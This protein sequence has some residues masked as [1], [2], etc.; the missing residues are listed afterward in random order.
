MS[1]S[2]TLQQL[3]SQL[4]SSV[5]GGNLI[6]N[7]TN[8]AS[9]T[10]GWSLQTMGLSSITIQIPDPSTGIVYDASKAVLTIIGKCTLFTGWDSVSYTI[11]LSSGDAGNTLTYANTAIAATY[12]SFN[13][14]G[15]A[16]SS[17]IP[18]NTIAAKLLPS[19][20]MQNVPL[21]VIST[22]VTTLPNCILNFG[23]SAN[24][25]TPAWSLISALGLSM[26]TM[27]FQVS[28]NMN[29]NAV[30]SNSFVLSGG[31]SIGSIETEITVTLPVDVFS[32]TN[33][34]SLAFSS[35]V[36]ESGLNIANLVQN[37]GGVN[38]YQEFPASLTALLEF[39]LT[40]FYV[41]FNPSTLTV[42]QLEINIGAPAWSVIP[43]EFSIENTNFGVQ[44]LNPFSSTSRSTT[45]F[46]NGT[47]LVGSDPQH[48]V[49]TLTVGA[50]LPLGSSNWLFNIY[51]EI[52]NV[53]YSTLV[54]STPGMN[55]YPP[56]AAPNGFQLE[57]I[58]LEYLNISFNPTTVTLSEVDLSVKSVLDFPIVPNII[59]IQNPYFS[60]SLTNPLSSSNNNYS[61]D[62]GG[63]ITLTNAPFLELNASVAKTTG[64][65]FNAGLAPGATINIID[66]LDQ[67]FA[68]SSTVPSWVGSTLEITAF[69]IVIKTPPSGKTSPP[70]EYIVSGTVV[71]ELVVGAFSLPAMTA[72]V[73]VDY[74]SADG[75]KPAV[76]SGSITVSTKLFGL[77]FLIGYKFGAAETDVY[78]VWNGIKAEYTSTSTYSK[79]TLTVSNLS[80]GSLISAVMS[81]LI[82]GFTLSPPWNLLNDINLD[83][84]SIVCTQ[85]IQA[86]DQ[87]KNSLVV[88]IPI[89]LNLGFIDIKTATLTRSGSGS[90]AQTYLGF[91]GT[92]L[93]FTI[94]SDSQNESAKQ[95]ADKGAPVNNMPTVPGLGGNI[96]DLQYF[97][98]GQ[99]VALYPTQNLT[100]VTQAVSELKTV[101]GDPP[102]QQPGQKA[103]IPIPPKPNSAP[104]KS[105]LIFDET[106]NWLIGLQ[107]KVMNT[108]SL[109]VVFNDPNLYG[110]AVGL[111]G[112]SAKIFAGLN[113][114]I[115]YKKV[116]DS[117]GVYQLDLQLPTAMRTLELGEVSITLPSAAIQIYT[118]G[119]FMVDL[120]FPWSNNFS[121][122]F[123][124]QVF[125]F[126]GQGGFYFG[127]LNS[128]TSSSVP[129]SQVGSF[130]P[131][132][133]LGVG[134]SLGVG[135]NINEGILSAGLSLMAVGV[136]QGVLARFN[137]NDTSLYTGDGDYYFKATG[138]FGL[139]GRIYGSVNFAIIS[140]S[141][142]LTAYA[143]I[144]ISLECYNVIDISFTAGVSISLTVTVNLGLFKIHITLKFSA[145]ISASFTI[146]TNRTALAPWNQQVKS[147]QLNKRLMSSTSYAVIP[148]YTILWQP[149]QPDT[150]VALNLMYLPLLSVSNAASST[151]AQFVN[152]LFIDAP[153]P[154]STTGSIDSSFTTL[155]TATL[156]W[157]INAIINSDK[158][159]TVTKVS[160]LMSQAVTV[161]ELQA[162]YDYLTY[163]SED[164][165]PI[166]YANISNHQEYDIRKFFDTYFKVTIQAQ[167]VDN[168]SENN[169]TVIPIFPDLKLNYSLNGTVGTPVDFSANPQPFSYLGEVQEQLGQLTVGYQSETEVANDH[170]DHFIPVNDPSLP[171]TPPDVS[172]ATFII[173]DYFEMMV[174]NVIQDAI[175]A[176]EK[177]NYH[178]DAT[179]SLGDVVNHFTQ[180]PLNNELTADDVVT[181]NATLLLNKGQIFNLSG[182]TY[183]IASNDTLNSIVTTYNANLVTANYITA[184]DLGT[185][186]NAGISGLIVQ[187]TSIVVSGFNPYIVIATDS[188][189]TIAD[190]LVPTTGSANATITQVINA[191]ADLKALT[192]L[193]LI[194]IPSLS[195]TTGDTDTFQSLSTKYGVKTILLATDNLQV[196]FN[197][198]SIIVPGITTLTVQDV[199]NQV[200]TLANINTYS[201]MAARFLLHG[202]NLPDPTDNTKTKPLYV[203]TGQQLTIPPL[204]QN[205]TY[206]LEL[207]SCANGSWIGVD[208]SAASLNVDNNEISRINNLLLQNI[209]QDTSPQPP[210]ALTLY[211]DAYLAFTLKSQIPWQYP[212]VLSLP[213]GT[214]PAQVV[215][216]PSIWYFPDTLTGALQDAKENLQLQLLLQTLN[217]DGN[218]YT[219]S[220]IQ[221]YGWATLVNIGVEKINDQNVS[222][223]IFANTYNL[224][225]AS[226]GDI[227]YLERIVAALNSGNGPQ[228]DQIRIMYDPNP[229]G[230]AS[231]D[232]VQSLTDGAYQIGVVKI[233][234]ST[235]TNPETGAN[236]LMS[237]AKATYTAPEPNT[238][239]SYIDFLS[240][241]WE[242]S[243]TRSGGFYLYFNEIASN[244]GLPDSLFSNN[245]LANLYLLITYQGAPSGNYMNAVTVGDPIDTSSSVLFVQ[246]ETLKTRNA[247]MPPGNTGFELT[248][249]NPGAYTPTVP[250]PIPATPSS[251]AED[252]L[253]LKNQ[254]NLIGYKLIGNSSF[255]A[256]PESLMPVGPMNTSNPGDGNKEEPDLSKW[257]YQGTI[258]VY[259]FAISRIQ[260]TNPLFPVAANDPYSG[261]GNGVQIQLSLVDLFGNPINSNISGADGLLTAEM[262]YTDNLMALSQWPNISSRF[263]FVT[264]ENK[265]N[266]Q[267]D[268]CFDTSRYSNANSNISPQ[269]LAQADMEIYAAIYYQLIQ[270]D[271]E[272]SYR[273]SLYNSPQYPEGV[274]LTPNQSL[275]DFVGT[276]YAYLAHI[277]DASK[278][279]VTV[280]IPW[281]ILAA[282]EA[283]NM[284]NIYELVT[285]FTITRTANIDSNF[286]NVPAVSSVT[287]II[288]PITQELCASDASTSAS[289]TYFASGFETVFLNNPIVGAY[290]KVASGVDSESVS[291]NGD[292][293]KV[294][295]VRFDPSG[296][297]GINVSFNQSE[298]EPSAYYYSPAPLSTSLVTL[299]NTPITP[300]V[301]GTPFV[302]NPKAATKNFASVDLDQWGL[303]CLQAIDNFLSPQYSVPAFLIDNGISLQA[304]LDAKNKL[305]NY[306]T[307]TVTNILDQPLDQA[308]INNAQEVFNQQLLINLSNAYNISTIIQHPLTVASEYTTSNTA[309]YN[310]PPINP[311][312]YGSLNGIDPRPV[313]SI[314]SDASTISTQYSFTNGKI[315]IG[316]GQS[317]VNYCLYVKD[318]SQ[319]E[320]F[321]FSKINFILSNI[322]HQI[323][324]VP[325]VEGYQ[326]STWL[327]FVIP[328]SNSTFSTGGTVD[329]PVPLR[330]YPVPP[331]VTAQSSDYN[332][333]NVTGE[334]T[335][336]EDALTWGFLYEYSQQEATQDIINAQVAFNTSTPPSYKLNNGS[337]VTLADALAQFITSL[338][339][340]TSDFL[341]YVAAV[342]SQDVAQNSS[343]AQKAKATVESLASLASLVATG[344]STQNQFN[345]WPPLPTENISLLAKK[346]GEEKANGV[347]FNYTIDESET[348]A[349][350]P[351]SPLLLTITANPE[352]PNGMDDP[353][354][355]IAGY[356]SIKINSE[357]GMVRYNFQDAEKN[358]LSYENRQ[359]LNTRSFELNP[360]NL[361]QYQ[362]GWAGLQVTRNKNL[363]AA[364]NTNSLFLYQTP[365]VRFYT[366][367]VPMLTANA[368]IDISAIASGKPQVNYLA[369]QLQN[370]FK[371]IFGNY[372]LPGNPTIRLE[373]LYSYNL[374]GTA[375]YNQIDLPIFLALPFEL[376]LQTDLEIGSAPPYC[377]TT[378]SF[379]CN[380]ASTL[381]DWFKGVNPNRQN[382][383]FTFKLI[384]Y[385]A[386][387]DTTPLISLNNLSLP[388][389]DI[390]ELKDN[391]E[392]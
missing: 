317:W 362:E 191:I 35:E 340:L 165:F 253:F 334:T 128:V 216:T 211:Q 271:V 116:N 318:A 46:V 129:T 197:A 343:V 224:S 257:P 280:P 209:T 71:W 47:F 375:S 227:V 269:Q 185:T 60:L 247:T 299:N 304:V 192:P 332:Q 148:P 36:G 126:I 371:A 96:F 154:S 68:P 63:I 5:S 142:D 200:I 296:E 22:S 360:L 98:L 78:L 308:Q 133:E 101:F 367:L 320:S 100:T 80:L 291:S 97:G 202:L 288:R 188:L 31:V 19:Y 102:V 24:P 42:N 177:Y 372:G 145:T 221:N 300:Y 358:Y 345:P 376:N 37:L 120:G 90:T 17:L 325:N 307:G 123:T 268:L 290:L 235:E 20:L 170:T 130:N 140:A 309:P 333:N 210:V 54:A 314:G 65:V 254:F 178:L 157:S 303:V 336:I 337:S 391:T 2:T 226:G 311:R 109:G 335:T 230:N 251:T 41:Q 137:V 79:Y 77:D 44:V 33:T 252:V 316:K 344:W 91:T 13:I 244:T 173:Q 38:V 255:E 204:V 155:A 323:E 305:A 119:N 373:A 273:T 225:G 389:I 108:V 287:T 355:K 302:Y 363:V 272:V 295:V 258:P 43:N 52:D 270:P 231:T 321:E 115:L 315:P 141:F 16:G 213:I 195:Y 55:T 124:V 275:S 9:A 125:P 168:Q 364:Y 92:F 132:I 51:G 243:I 149:I 310:L 233:N 49:A 21:S 215:G 146:G 72:N 163:E 45:L 198:T 135:K 319:V 329:V 297:N 248:I 85:Y 220:E 267:I 239:N 106:S 356:D 89:N 219:Q 3:A 278:P 264:I 234:L 263:S 196:T 388:I 50:T 324:N 169:A 76:T 75:V 223:P 161:D 193:T 245:P 59:G 184:T 322:E 139:T 301:S 28:N 266:I 327:A 99:H 118:N 158:P 83:G 205:D 298:N 179:V 292:N 58:V 259:P 166:M 156:Q 342:T 172:F 347:A 134:L 236:V 164:F 152:L 338:P 182:I 351:T 171:A 112:D 181:A 6:L 147:A 218:T 294:W 7:K 283:S 104:Q 73:L 1:N 18:S 285:D 8:V 377:T 346:T 64:W 136:F 187:G 40:Y 25:I 274:P 27:G 111:S 214:P 29:K 249:N 348:T 228:I 199:E 105:M 385:S 350:D 383:M 159:G 217:A 30:I 368:Q 374:N 392:L 250:Y 56:P 74:I 87:S 150:Q 81:D 194:D 279:E 117:I 53:D 160:D 381:I 238:L 61:G 330:A 277:A 62:V 12:P 201:S 390:N 180:A 207:S 370:L 312:L 93:G 94:S 208:A 341:T 276:V 121:R 69:Q 66:L 361:M 144:T 331:S 15:I 379:L 357:D 57:K 241:V 88:S 265:S 359:V 26:S 175:K 256:S 386:S 103:I 384:I 281:S 365:L 82:P 260:P 138:T 153:D 122:S 107:C 339:D 110:L 86:A 10:F 143:Y 242:C 34:W 176:F 237:L 354:V 262:A 328:L 151:Q 222:A 380:V 306:I 174:K 352:N 282:V 206:N 212:G 369:V 366:P 286:I 232:G 289:L 240:F 167:N 67:F 382:G 14:Q 95:L 183:P 114:E 378:Q 203:L 84:L 229:S 48:P 131:V 186:F 284:E 293:Q 387:D 113:F 190:A 261:N 326:A 189:R 4:N 127:V 11:T 353:L 313:G 246:S 349:G 70:T 39:T 32:T 162:I 23:V